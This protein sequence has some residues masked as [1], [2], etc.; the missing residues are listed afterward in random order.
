MILLAPLGVDVPPNRRR[1]RLLLV[2]GPA[3]ALLIAGTLVASWRGRAPEPDLGITVFAYSGLDSLLDDGLLKGFAA[4]YEQE[5]GDR[6]AI[7][8]Q[9]AGS[10]ELVQALLDGAP[11]QIAILAS[12]IDALDLVPDLV[13]PE[14]W[15]TLPMHG[16]LARSPLVFLVRDAN[17]LGVADFESLVRSDAKLV[18]PMPRTSGLGTYTLLAAYAEGLQTGASREVAFGFA[19]RLKY[20]SLCPALNARAG[21]RCFERGVGDVCV[22]YEH[23]VLGT[24]HHEPAMGQVV[25]PAHTVLCEPVVVALR[26]NASP[27]QQNVVDALLGYLWSREAMTVLSDHGF[28]RPD[29]DGASQGLPGAV[30][31][32]DLGGSE[33]LK[34]EV[35]PHLLDT[36][37]AH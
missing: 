18:R 13:R 35:L 25:R 37:S 6:V 4:K 20:S 27:A 3:L 12:E 1:R 24:R 29:A 14:A 26:R 17:P 2:L 28:Q 10:R 16:V 33:V 30:T 5:S 32:S 8:R 34:R 31:L 22:A 19:A 21:R 23:D 9:F 15:R 36:G 7:R 11:A